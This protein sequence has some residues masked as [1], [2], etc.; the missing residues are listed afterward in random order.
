MIKKKYVCMRCEAKF[1]LEIF[2]PGEA[3]KKNTPAYRVGCP[4]CRSAEVIEADKL[5]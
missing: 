1:E 3:Q 4:N 5:R 2:E